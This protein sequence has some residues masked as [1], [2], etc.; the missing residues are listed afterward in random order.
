MKRFKSILVVCQEDCQPELAIERARILAQ[1][2]GASITLVDVISLHE[3]EMAEVVSDVT[4]G[5]SH[6]LKTRLSNYHRA[7]LVEYGQSLRDSGIETAIEVLWGVVFVEII[8]AVLR[9]GHDLVIKSVNP[10]LRFRGQQIFGGLDMHL[11]RKCPCPVWI[12]KEEFDRE[13]LRV[14]A[15]VDPD[16]SDAEREG[17]NRLVMDLSTS[18]CPAPTG[19]VHVVHA[20]TL[21]EKRALLNGAQERATADQIAQ[22]REKVCALRAQALDRLISHYPAD[23]E[24]R[25]VHLLQG[26][27]AEIVPDFVA[28]NDIDLVVMGTVRRTDVPGVFMGETAEIMLNRMNSS[29]LAVK[30]HDFR[31]PIEL[32]DAATASG[33]SAAVPRRAVR[34]V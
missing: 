22:I 20:W 29:V 10:S 17:L 26:E 8:R 14:L 21:E 27:A 13:D 5:S 7:R 31:T 2:N 3:T 12:L 24:R 15:A 34:A 18:V 32:D 25:R 16:P 23:D 11:M 1:Q 9:G 30:P 19:Q 28:K 4:D 6:D 33:T